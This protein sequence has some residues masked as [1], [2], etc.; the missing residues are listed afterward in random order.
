MRLQCGY[1]VVPFHATNLAQ[2]LHAGNHCRRVE[3]VVG[4]ALDQHVDACLQGFGRILRFKANP[5]AAGDSRITKRT[6]PPQRNEL[7]RL[8]FPLD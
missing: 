4:P 1:D 2:L 8:L 6:P 5:G 3:T 7:F